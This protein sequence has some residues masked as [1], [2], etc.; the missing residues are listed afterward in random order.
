MST[1]HILTGLLILAL[2]GSAAPAAA[3]PRESGQSRDPERFSRNVPL[4][5]TGSVS[6][7]NVS[8]DIV[9]TGGPGEQVTIEAV[10]RGR[11]ADALRDVEIEV[12]ASEGRVEINTKY[13]RETRSGRNQASVSYTLTV[14]RAASVRLRSISGDIEASLID[15]RLQAD[16]ISGNV[17]IA[18]AAQLDSARAVSGTVRV[19]S[20]STSGTLDVGTVSGGIYLAGVKARAVDASTV[21]GDVQLTDVTCERV[22]TKSVSGDLEFT[23][24]LAK[25]G[26]YVLQAHSGDV[27]V[28][29]LNDIGFE[30]TAGSFSGSVSSDIPLTLRPGSDPEDRRRRRQEIRGVFGDGAAA[31]ELRSFSGSIRITNRDGGPSRR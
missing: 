13:P 27:R 5:K 14:P 17:T 30:V 4:G 9:V 16:T 28:R 15:G 19:K 10:K 24:A 26:R 25:G 31:L 23:G 12:I 1:R 8:G 21:S 20:A 7:R 18:Q 2:L 6:L 3:G 11:T 29:V 22:T